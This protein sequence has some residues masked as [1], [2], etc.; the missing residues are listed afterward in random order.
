MPETSNSHW[1][2]LGG[3]AATRRPALGRSRRA[4]RRHVGRRARRPADRPR[5]RRPGA[6]RHHDLRG[7]RA[8]ASVFLA[9]AIVTQLLGVVVVTA[10]DA[11]GLAD[12]E[13]AAARHHAPRARPRPRVPPPAHAG[14]A[15]PTRRRRRHVR[16]RLPVAG[17]AEGRRRGPAA[18]G[19][20]RRAARARLAAR[21]RH[22][23]VPDRRRPL[24][25]VSMRHR[26][27]RESSDE[28]GSLR[29]A[30]RRHRGAADRDR[31]PARQRRRGPRHVAVRRGQRRCAAE[32]GAPGGG[33]PADVVGAADR[34]H[35]RVGRLARAVGA[36]SSP[37]ARSRSAPRS[38]CSSTC[39]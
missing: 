28:M 22:G 3:V 34:G 37:T 18:R 13:R 39:S 15:D 31:G 36:G 23:R 5:D 4:H 26:A 35:G 20:A 21:R 27:V 6:A 12:H 7:R 9:V 8:S 32:L 14:R 24:L 11:G 16:V 29:Q 17:G 33:V 10:G 2:A 38:C 19:H 1:R 25:V 30:L